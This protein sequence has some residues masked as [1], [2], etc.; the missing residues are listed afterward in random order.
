M[1]SGQS[2]KRSSPQA[3]DVFVH[4]RSE[5]GKNFREVGIV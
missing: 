3:L 4:R 2:L 5:L 1:F